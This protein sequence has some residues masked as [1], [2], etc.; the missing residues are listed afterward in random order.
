MQPLLL[1]AGFGLVAIG[2]LTGKKKPVNVDP[3]N[4]KTMPESEPTHDE[5]PV[6]EQSSTTNSGESGNLDAVDE[7][8]T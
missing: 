8:E 1:L 6:I 4:A 2:V 7:I 3:A 5:K